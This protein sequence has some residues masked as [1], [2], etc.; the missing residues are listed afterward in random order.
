ME[1]ADQERSLQETGK[2]FFQILREI[3]EQSDVTRETSVEKVAMD[4]LRFINF[5]VR[6]EKSFKIKF[7]D[8]RLLLHEYRTIGDILTQVLKKT[9]SSG[10]ERNDA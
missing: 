4:S 9:G 7:E 6:L 5:I 10:G 3:T 2:I 8:E 1:A